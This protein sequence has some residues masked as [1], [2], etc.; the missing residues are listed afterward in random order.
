LTGKACNFTAIAS[1][2]KSKSPAIALRKSGS[3]GAS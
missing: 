2:V 3:A 1:H